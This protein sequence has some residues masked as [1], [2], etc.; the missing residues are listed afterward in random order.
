[1]SAAIHWVVKAM[2]PRDG[3]GLTVGLSNPDGSAADCGHQHATDEE[4]FAC[5]WTPDPWPVVC[6]LHVV[7]VRTETPPIQA[8]LPW[9]PL[10]R[11]VHARR[12]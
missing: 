5:P 7:Q 3:D 11:R 9:A 10:S 12:P 6:D 2:V 4:A 1:M 8:E